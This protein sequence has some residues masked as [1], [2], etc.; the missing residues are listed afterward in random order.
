MYF[1]RERKY[2]YMILNKLRGSHFYFN[3]T[4]TYYSFKFI[5]FDTSCHYTKKKSKKKSGG[6]I[7]KPI[8]TLLRVNYTNKIEYKKENH[9]PEYSCQRYIKH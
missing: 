8:F 5:Q 9:I 1:K 6:F 7:S 4:Y 3:K 2:E